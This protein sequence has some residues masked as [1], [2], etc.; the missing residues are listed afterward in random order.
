M[1]QKEKEAKL[2]RF[3]DEVRRRVIAI[4][5]L[6]RMQQ[7]QKSQTA[8]SSTQILVFIILHR[9]HA[10]YIA[11]L[12]GWASSCPLPAHFLVLMDKP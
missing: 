4:D 8:V 2:Q 9:L 3:Q 11:E 10:A 5:R 12:I 1:L 6:K 7:L